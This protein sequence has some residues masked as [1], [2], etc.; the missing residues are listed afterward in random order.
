MHCSARVLTGVIK[1]PTHRSDLGFGCAW[2]HL[3]LLTERRGEWIQKAQ[4]GENIDRANCRSEDA[5]CWPRRPA[6]QT[7]Q[8]ACND[9]AQ[10]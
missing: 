3:P 6:L 9:R 10:K 5:A 7:P 1:L 8:D 2:W 4:P